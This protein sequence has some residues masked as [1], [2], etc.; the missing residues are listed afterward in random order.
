MNFIPNADAAIWFVREVFPKIIAEVPNAHLVIAGANPIPTVRALANERITVTGYIE[1]MGRE[2]AR[3]TVYVAPLI[4]GGGFKN[5][6]IEAIANR[7]CV[8]ATSVA[9]EFL[10]PHIRQSIRVADS[11]PA[12]A[13][14]I[15]EVL[16]APEAVEPDVE[17]LYRRVGETFSWKARAKELLGLL[18]AR[19]GDIT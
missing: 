4:S 18:Q 16:R 5:K 11:P 19:L 2:I 13:E 3:S 10:D 6:V 7:T 8:V 1:D 17:S 15:V 14:S 12:M 9:V